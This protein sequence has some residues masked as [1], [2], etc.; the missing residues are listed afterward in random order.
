[1]PTQIT[2]NEADAIVEC[3]YEH[4]FLKSDFAGVV[5]GNLKVAAEH[6]AFLFFGDCTQLPAASS[7]FDVYE[8]VDMLDSLNVDRRMREALVISE[9]PQAEAAFGFYVTATSNRGLKVRVF[10]DGG[11]A[12]EWLLEQG[13]KIRKATD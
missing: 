3:V 11:Q 1:M 13:E 7:L 12:R 5:E 8:L 2:Y 4:P 6:G 9:D 10:T